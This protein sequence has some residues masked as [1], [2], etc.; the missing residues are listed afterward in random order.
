MKHIETVLGPI[1]PSELGV[2][3]M[4]EHLI[5]DQSLY[6]NQR[7]DPKPEEKFLDEPLRID[8]IQKT[9]YYYLH[10]HRDNVIQNDA[11]EA[12]EE[13]L[14]YKRAGG[15]SIADCSCYGIERDPLVEREVSL[16]TGVQIVMAT[17]FY[18]KGSC[19]EVETLGTAEKASLFVRELTEGVGDT[20]IK[21]GFI[22]EIGVSEGVPECE[23]GSLA[24]AGRAQSETGA[25]ILVHQPGLLKVGHEILD[26]IE[27]NGGSAERTDLCH[28]DP[29]SDDLD[30]LKSLLDRGA[31]LS[32]DQF[33]L[34]CWIRIAGYKG[35]WLPRDIDRVRAIARLCELGYSRQIVLSQDISFKT[36]Y[37]KYGGGGYAHVLE[38]I[39]PIMRAEGIRE[40]SI[41]HMLVENPARILTLP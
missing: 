40:R 33:G 26:I 9:R 18:S 3:M 8:T 32:F 30:Y 21:A 7:E 36:S 22:G 35:L 38:D 2:T 16:K 11:E 23:E 25:A 4:H 39:L 24:A 15:C 17:G 6:L 29:L 12:A 10:A 37:V 5:W 19:P 41:R 1:E 34:E 27:E 28:C 14:C 20:G 31:T 13:I